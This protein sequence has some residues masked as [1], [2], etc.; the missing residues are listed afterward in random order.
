MKTTCPFAFVH[1]N[2]YFLYYDQE[3]T[4]CLKAQT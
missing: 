2:V 1:V 4:V 3:T